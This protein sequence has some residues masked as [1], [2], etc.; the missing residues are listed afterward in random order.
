MGV[1][2][3]R[4]AMHDAGGRRH[5]YGRLGL[6]AVTVAAMLAAMAGPAAAAKAAKPDKSSSSAAA[7]PAAVGDN[8]SENEIFTAG[9]NGATTQFPAAGTTIKIGDT[10]GVYYN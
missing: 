6:G 9:K 7:T 1:E 8:C 10:I 2:V 4:A 5:R 3:E